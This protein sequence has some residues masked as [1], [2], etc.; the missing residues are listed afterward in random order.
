MKIEGK[1]T[2]INDMVVSNPYVRL[3]DVISF[4]VWSSCLPNALLVRLPP[5][6]E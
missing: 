4:L 1:G 2:A 5:S 3:T 6:S